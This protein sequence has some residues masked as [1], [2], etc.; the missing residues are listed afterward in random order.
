VRADIGDLT[1]ALAARYA[2]LDR[3]VMLAGIADR[4][5]QRLASRP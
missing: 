4:C 5:E 2:R 3:A 1:R